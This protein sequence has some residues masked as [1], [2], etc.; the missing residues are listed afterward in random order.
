M[1]AIALVLCGLVLLMGSTL[2]VAAPTNPATMEEGTS[3]GW[4]TETTVDRNGNGIGDMIERYADH[5]LFLDD[6]GTLPIIVDFD[7]DP[8]DAD[9]SMLED[10]VDLEHAFTLHLIHA[11]AGRMPVTELSNA[12][13]L[14]GV[15]MLELD[16]LLT[17]AMADVVPTHNV[18]SVWEDTGYTGLGATVA[19]IDTGID[20]AHAGLDDM[21][22]DNATDD[23][24]VIAF[25]D[26][27]N[28]PNLRNG[29]EVFP[30]DD[31]GH[32]TH[33]AGI[34]AGTGAPDH[35]HIGVAPGARLV[36]VKVLD[37]G[38]SG[39]FSVVMAGMEWTVEKRHVF[40]I[41]SASMSLG[42]PGVIEWTSSE[43][44][45]V[46]RMANR[47]MEENVALFIA[48]GNS[49][50]S[51][52]IGTPGSAEDAI[53]V[54]SLDKDTGIAVYSSQ[55]PTEEG[56]IKPNIAF[57]GSDVMAPDFNTGTGY[58]AKS[59]T[60]MATPGAAGVGALMAEA[61]PE[62]TAFEMRNMMQE[63]ATYRQCHY[64][65]A[66]EPCAEDL[67]PKNR[68]NNVYGHGHVWA[69]LSLLAAAETEYDLDA[70]ISSNVSN[71]VDPVD[72]RVHVEPGG[73][74]DIR[75]NQPID[76]VHWRS[77]DLRDDWTPLHSHTRGE[78]R[79]KLT[80]TDLAH[81]L[82]HLPETDLAGNHTISVRGVV[83]TSAGV[84]ETIDLTLIT[85][86]AAFTEQASTDSRLGL[87]IGALSLGVLIGAIAAIGALIVGNR[88]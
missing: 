44:D 41:R 52:Q 42:G 88:R 45:S 28:T 9:V 64:M 51:A 20:G 24:K 84:V 59:G 16:G 15:V 22:D 77:N 4:W 3:S 6:R 82:E 11:V 78:Q 13:H 70:N 32:G 40:N 43:E 61:N 19:I 36:G 2:A 1:R 87:A 47:M 25:Y 76:V 21:D 58:T 31:Q 8:T 57:V 54:G 73:I 7:H 27:V 80:H 29:T 33:C 66:N 34:T 63:T 75:F 60:S 65:G 67:L 12:L 69:D 49:F 81:H 50:V 23:P 72:R 79:V 39:S 35:E 83:G 26:P 37:A 56:R 62:L 5:P 74:I 14:P 53:T 86:Q 68:Q 10:E 46:N 55:G 30:Y 38:G 85:P 17:T 18:D 71:P 48:A